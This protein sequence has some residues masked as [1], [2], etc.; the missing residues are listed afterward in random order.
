MRRIA[1][2][3]AASLPPTLEVRRTRPDAGVVDYP[4]RLRMSRDVQWMV[5]LHSDSRAGVGLEPAPTGCWQNSGAAGFAVLWSDEG[6]ERLVRARLRLAEVIRDRLVEAGFL[7]YGGQDYGGLYEGGNGVFVDRH[8]P[9]KRIML[10][11]RPQVPSVIIE[12]HQAWDP[13]EVARWSEAE[14]WA[15]F[16][17]AL[18]AALADLGV[19]PG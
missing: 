9:S 2:G 7:A 14:T 17:S 18:S 10:L 5:S 12:T 19:E 16:A 1:D 4:T 15:V 8:L 6:A 13:D 3:V 11:R